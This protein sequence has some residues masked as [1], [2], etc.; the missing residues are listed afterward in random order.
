MT[1]VVL[2]LKALGFQS[3]EDNHVYAAERLEDRPQRDDHADIDIQFLPGGWSE[4]NGF[5]RWDQFFL[6][7]VKKTVL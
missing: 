2:P 7:L 1:D 5:V 3:E 6:L 4:V